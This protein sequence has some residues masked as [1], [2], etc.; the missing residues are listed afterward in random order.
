MKKAIGWGLLI[1]AILL[2]WILP[3]PLGS[4]SRSAETRSM[5]PEAFTV[6]AA[7]TAAPTAKPTAKRPAR[8]TAAPA[9]RPTAAPTPKP[10]ATPK[11]TPALQ[12][13]IL[14]T[15][16]HKF[17]YPWCSSVDQMKEKNKLEYE[18]SREEII[19]MGYAPCQRCHP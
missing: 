5:A 18:G 15:N 6:E 13:Y 10:T 1:T 8:P 12:T 4:G 14:N 19:E 17:H 7:V 3:S 9:A 2:A 16:T 11:P